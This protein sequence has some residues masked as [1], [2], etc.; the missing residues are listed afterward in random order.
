MKRIV[1][2]L[3]LVQIPIFAFAQS[4][5]DDDEPNRQIVSWGL[6]GGP[7]LSGYTSG[8]NDTLYSKPSVGLDVAAYLAYHISDRWHLQL[9]T[10]L[11]LERIGISSP[12]NGN[13]MLTTFGLDIFLPLMYR[14][15]TADGTWLIGAGPYCHFVFG[16]DV[17]QGL[18]PYHHRVSVDPVTGKPRFA[19]CDFNSGVDIIAGY[20]FR[21]G[22]M[23]RLDGKIGFTDLLNYEAAG[24]LLPYKI[25][26]SLGYCFDN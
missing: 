17:N 22:W 19:L 14:L 7:S 11:N 9:A 16:S 5:L 2:A 12:V 6:F 24:Y 18:N 13:R 15:P 26:V 10:A 21:S 23:L 1:L 20:E 8:P 4:N 3:L 25:T